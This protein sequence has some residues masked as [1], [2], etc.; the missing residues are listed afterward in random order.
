MRHRH[1]LAAGGAGGCAAWTA[2]RRGGGEVRSAA[3]A[4]LP[5]PWRPPWPPILHLPRAG[6]DSVVACDL[7]E[8]VCDVARRSAAHNGLSSR[9]SVVHCDAGMLQR[10]REVR[11]LGINLVVA[12]MFDAGGRGAGGG[13]PCAAPRCAVLCCRG[14]CS[15][16]HPATTRPPVSR[17]G[18]RA[19]A[20]NRPAGRQLRLRSGPGAQAGGAAGGGGG[21]R[22]RDPVL[23]GCGGA[24]GPGRRLRPVSDGHIPVRERRGWD[25]GGH[26]RAAGTAGRGRVHHGCT[27][28][29]PR[30]LQPSPPPPQP[31]P[32]PPPPPLRPRWDAAYEAVDA[33]ALPHR[34]LTKPA[35]VFEQWFDGERKPRGRCGLCAQPASWLPALGS[36]AHAC[37]CSAAVPGCCRRLHPAALPRPTRPRRLLRPHQ[38]AGSR[39]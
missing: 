8:S 11:Q 33:S 32:Q 18:P 2:C 16:A 17:P 15:R 6:A 39:S 9:V 1:P 22:R 29:E 20:H 34:R 4:A 19:P 27:T 7:H 38:P 13:G 25:R 10:G 14:S 35:K 24:H 12:D 26:G 21:A 5:L 37:A 31:S 36:A 23:H 3:P 30:H 28:G